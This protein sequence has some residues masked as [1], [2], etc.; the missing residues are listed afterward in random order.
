MVKTKMKDF[1]AC[2]RRIVQ[3]KEVRYLM[4]MLSL[5]DGE[6]GGTIKFPVKSMQCLG[7]V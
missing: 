5:R 3:R 2:S 1:E 4:V 7:N 6:D